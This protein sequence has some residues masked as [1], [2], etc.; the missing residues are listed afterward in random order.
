VSA[1][2]KQQSPPV[3]KEVSKEIPRKQSLYRTGVVS[4]EIS[5]QLYKTSDL[6]KKIEALEYLYNKYS[7]GTD[8]SEEDFWSHEYWSEDFWNRVVQSDQ[9][10][11][12]DL[13]IVLL[14]I[15]SYDKTKIKSSSMNMVGKSHN[16]IQGKIKKLI[17]AN[18][19]DR[20]KE[21]IRKE[22]QEI[23]SNIM[24]I[25]ISIKTNLTSGSNKQD[26]ANTNLGPE[27][28]NS[29]DKYS[30]DNLKENP[31]VLDKEQPDSKYAKNILLLEYYGIIIM[32]TLI[33]QEVLKEVLSQFK[34]SSQ[35][36]KSFEAGI[37]RC[38][39]TQ[40]LDLKTFTTYRAEPVEDSQISPIVT[41][42][43]SACDKIKNILDSFKALP[44]DGSK[45]ELQ[46]R[47]E[48]L[49][50]ACDEIITSEINN[51]TLH[52]KKTLSQRG[53]HFE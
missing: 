10:Q 31:Q 14:D 33:S 35:N 21:T 24:P 45:K 37:R 49:S 5:Q 25:I 28:P 39:M 2:P 44:K 16:N 13:N 15:R 6:P 22:L 48:E 52:C 36:Q 51:L 42:S 27:D 3:P 19:L 34:D 9:F 7:G 12:V 32:K 20:E 47:L 29:D 4:H 26:L 53:L 18:T 41:L 23:Y 1:S 11:Q 38:Y 8:I 30:I 46:G 43:S 50:N 40:F 17:D